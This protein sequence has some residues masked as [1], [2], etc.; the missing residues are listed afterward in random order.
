VCPPFGLALDGRWSV[1]GLW[2]L[3]F[4]FATLALFSNGFWIQPGPNFQ[5]GLNS[6]PRLFMNGF[7][8]ALLWAPAAWYGWSTHR[9]HRLLDVEA[10][11]QS[12]DR[13]A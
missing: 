4:S 6:A 9:S 12:F 10:S 2:W 11:P 7:W 8:F 3:A 13:A 5:A 1:S